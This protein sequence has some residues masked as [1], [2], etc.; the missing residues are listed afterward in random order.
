MEAIAQN[1]GWTHGR[2]CVVHLVLTLNIAVLS[3]QPRT[4][5]AVL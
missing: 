4:P 1:Q 5:V 3:A 2:L